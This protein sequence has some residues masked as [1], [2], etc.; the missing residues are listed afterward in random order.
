MHKTGIPISAL[1]ISP[2]RTHAI[3]AGR[4]I[5]KT[6]QIQGET[7]AED[8]NLRSTIIAYAST[9]NV[10]R[11]VIPAQHKDQLAANDVKWS[12]GRFDTTIATAAANGRIVLYDI[13]RAGV[14]LARLH[15]HTRQVH[16]VAFNP[17][18]G[19]LLLSGSQDATIRMWDI[20]AVAGDRSVMT[21]QS[22]NR[23]S[24][25]NESI[26]DLR[27]SPTDG[28]EFAA[29]TDN[30]VIQRWDIRK[31]NAPLLKI[32]A[33]DKTCHSVDWHPSGKYLASAGAD[34]NVKVWDFK[35]SD[36]RMK[37]SW[38]L[39]APQ[40]VLN[41]R[42]RPASGPSE[43]ED[44]SGQQC[45][46]LATLYD[47]CDPRIH[48]WDFRRPYLPY[49]EIDR[50]ETAATDMLWCSEDLL[51][52]VGITG[53][54]TQTDIKYVTKPIERH[55]I[56]VLTT[57]PD[58]QV[59]YFSQA[60]ARRPMSFADPSN[61]FL[62]RTN[63]G[64][65]SGEKFGSSHS[66]TDG[67]LEEASMLSSSLK[68][69][70]QKALSTRTTASTTASTP[71][72][73]GGNTPTA[74][75]EE[76][77]KSEGRFHSDQVAAYGH[78]LGIFDGD[79]FMYLA[80]HYQPPLPL[81]RLRHLSNVHEVI[82]LMLEENALLAAY[83]GQY[84]LAQSWRVMGLAVR[85]ELERR[86]DT[87][88]KRS[89]L[90]PKT[91]ESNGAPDKRKLNPESH[92]VIQET[93]S[94]ATPHRPLAN[95]NV[96]STSNMPT[97]LA[98]PFQQPVAFTTADEELILDSEASDRLLGP[99]WRSKQMLDPQGHFSREG[100]LA[101]NRSA[102]TG[103]PAPH[104]PEASCSVSSASPDAPIIFGSF[105]DIDEQMHERRAA[106]N[107]Y[108][109]KP[110]SPLRLDEPFGVAQGLSVVPRLDRHDSNESFQMLSASTDSNPHSLTMVG[111]FEE[112]QKSNL[113]DPVSGIWDS[114]SL[115]HMPLSHEDRADKQ[116]KLSGNSAS[117]AIDAGAIEQERPVIAG[118][119]APVYGVSAVHRPIVPILP[120]VHQSV[121]HVH[122]GKSALEINQE[123]NDSVSEECSVALS[124]QENPLPWSA[125]AL[126]PPLLDFH[127][128][129]LSDTQ[130]PTFLT[131]Y[132]APLFPYLFDI[133]VVTA[134][135]L[136]YHQQLVSLN[137]FIEAASLRSYCYPTYASIWE[138]GTS[139]NNAT[140]WYCN[141]CKKAVTGDTVG[142]CARCKQD[143]G[144]CPIC[145]SS[146]SPLP[147]P[148]DLGRHDAH[149]PHTAS[150]TRGTK[151][152]AWCQECGHSG[153][154]SCL[155]VWWAD[156]VRSEGGCPSQGCLH[157]C[158]PG[159]RRNERMKRREDEAKRAQ[160]KA[161]GVVKDGWIV[162]ESRA[163][164][165]ARGLV[166]PMDK[167][168]KI[169]Q[170]TRALSGKDGALSAG[171]GL[172]GKR[173]RLV[174]PSA[175][176]DIVN[177]SGVDVEGVTDETSKSVP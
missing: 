77:M 68:K 14:E 155:R 13:N 86:D 88:H 64:G 109:A 107:N 17:H 11:G 43:P 65:S 169:G 57:A 112:S 5:L 139:E 102:V 31:A 82:S 138:R 16:R 159:T 126:I 20:R 116:G 129:T 12:H 32:N 171:L 132:L 140:G 95:T 97:P 56:N 78:V 147:F 120:V 35:S 22:I 93:N 134:T 44:L 136:S 156:A 23:F 166:A 98:K 131:L 6:I 128:N 167:S 69:R 72:S 41:A 54:F 99:A 2:G 51:W 52:S 34:K 168:P 103:V 176:G 18:Q 113:S 100:W 76:A 38:Q 160:V 84:R 48:I 7:C 144:L 39:R 25:N 67:S 3:L 110:R 104:E 108:R 15:E 30:G 124:P 157:D 146:K 92:E 115:K 24:G 45:T 81:E 62:Q 59:C 46:Y 149:D 114:G 137:L 119:F 55:N 91:I 170:F 145:E 9:H 130:L 150:D 141:N 165:R 85:N 75:L 40:A 106:M 26:R 8:F 49:R 174:E 47:Q 96:E 53:I 177:G 125:T 135:L 1:D 73:I 122:Q 133:S 27:W 63:T 101:S 4:D 175:E 158:M 89:E 163:V 10:S 74:R 80:Q 29:G 60:R 161:G 37:P 151:L 153:H 19:A 162:G 50:Y 152:W 123:D 121:A 94:T 173:V 118:L 21:C 111:S 71:P 164:E 70:R 36:R 117:L 148:G 142:F 61:A 127:L 87:P 79:A 105:T 28:V 172:G 83:T 42:W 143:W 66:A 33:H 154:S 90:R 58:G